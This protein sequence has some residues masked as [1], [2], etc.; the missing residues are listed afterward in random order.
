MVL[1]PIA[2]NSASTLPETPAMSERS[3]RQNFLPRMAIVTAD[4]I[5]I[6][7]PGFLSDRLIVAIEA[8]ALRWR[9]LQSFNA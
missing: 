4:M 7:L 9:R 1:G 3:E 2:P 5:S 6:G 8:W